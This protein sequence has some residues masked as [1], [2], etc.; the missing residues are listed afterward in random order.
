MKRTKKD[1]LPREVTNRLARIS[2]YSLVLVT[3]TFLGLYGG[4]YLDK[5]FGMAPNL[6]MLGLVAGIV[7]GF[8][9]FIHEVVIERKVKR[10]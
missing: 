7:L 5:V 3:M 8:K 1:K 4:M 6:T 9:G 2:G 10:S